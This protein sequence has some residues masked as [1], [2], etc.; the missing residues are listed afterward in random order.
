MKR[1]SLLTELKLTGFL[2]LFTLAFN[3]DAQMNTGNSGEPAFIRP[4][5]H[6]QGLKKSSSALSQI[7]LPVE[8]RLAAYYRYNLGHGTALESKQ[9][10][11]D[12]FVSSLLYSFDGFLSLGLD[13]DSLTTY[14]RT[15]IDSNTSRGRFSSIMTQFAMSLR[16]AHTWAMDTIV[17]YTPLAPGVPLLV[18]NAFATAEHFGAVLTALPDSTALVL[19]VVPNHPLGL[20]PGD[21]ILG[22]EGVPW[23][24]QV[25]ELI[26]ADLPINSTGVGTISAGMNARIRNVG[27][28]W[29]LFESIDIIK[30]SSKDTLHLAVA[31]L[32]DLSA[33][34]MMGTSNLKFRVSPFHFTVV[35]PQVL[36]ILLTMEN[37][38]GITLVYPTP[39]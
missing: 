29:H 7:L 26:A 30:Y 36:V 6:P 3:L 10:I 19:R 22:Y 32:I 23:K 25:Q 31:P 2:L 28:N 12:T 5:T 20:E 24:Y 16:D 15:K 4:L 9:E 13:F 11:F 14:Y 37:Y 21:I 1:L 34:P 39:G 17:T 8:G 27:N 35:I 33:D 38:P 18:L